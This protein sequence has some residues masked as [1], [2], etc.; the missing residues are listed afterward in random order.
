[1]SKEVIVLIDKRTNEVV[2]LLFKTDIFARIKNGKGVE[3]VLS[4]K[5]LALNFERI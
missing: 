2:R 3:I 4:L 1:M 5:S